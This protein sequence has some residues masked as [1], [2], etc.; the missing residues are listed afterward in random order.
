MKEKYLKNVV[1][2]S[3]DLEEWK[4]KSGNASLEWYKYNDVNVQ[5]LLR[6]APF[7]Q[8][9]LHMGGNGG[10][11][12][13]SRKNVGPSWR[14]VVELGPE[15]KAWGIYPGGPSGNPGSKHYNTYVQPWAAGEYNVLHLYANAEKAKAQGKNIQEFQPK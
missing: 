6:L 14:M 5:H 8:N 10:I 15:V 4:K 1:E 13:A 2:G 11:V 9:Q 12:N 3:E 7:G